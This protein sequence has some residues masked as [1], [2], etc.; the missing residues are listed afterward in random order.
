MYASVGA[1]EETTPEDKVKEVL[2]DLGLDIRGKSGSKGK[3]TSHCIMPKEENLTPL[4]V[5]RNRKTPLENTTYVMMIRK[6][7]NLK[8]KLITIVDD[9]HLPISR[10]HVVLL[11][12]KVQ[13]FNFVAVEEAYEETT[14]MEDDG[15][16]EEEHGEKE[17]EE[18]EKG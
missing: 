16:G 3:S 14:T 2:T 17:V 18:Q 13:K 11:E 5:S 10:N 1:N 7:D 12:G 9:I 15:E 4:K 6:Y 8:G